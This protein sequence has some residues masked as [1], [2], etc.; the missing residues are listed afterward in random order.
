MIKKRDKLHEKAGF[1]KLYE[2]SV[3]VDVTDC[4]TAKESAEKV[5]STIGGYIKNAIH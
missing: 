5:Y 2:K 1:N 3:K 4:K